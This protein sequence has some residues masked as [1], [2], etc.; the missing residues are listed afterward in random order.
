M[1]HTLGHSFVPPGIHAGGL[2]YHGDSPLVSLLV[3][4]KVIEARAYPQNPV[5]D[6][7]LLFARTEGVI[8][9][10]ETAHAVKAAVDEAVR[11]RE[12]GQGEVIVFN[13]SGHGHFDLA[14]YDDY[15]EN[16][17]E[18]YELPE[19]LLKKALEDL[20]RFPGK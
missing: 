11:C 19:E 12:T 1:M 20:P 18:D 4:E 16:K 3:H 7:A 14:A 2:R 13:F 5:F 6:A 8:P 17:L 9:A 15:L 10:P